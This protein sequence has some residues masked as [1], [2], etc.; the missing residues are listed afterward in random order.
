MRILRAGLA[1]LLGLGVLTATSPAA[2]HHA[3]LPASATGWLEII[4]SDGPSS[5]ST[6][7]ALLHTDH[8]TFRLPAASVAGLGSGAR[9]A[10][11]GAVSPAARANGTAQPP[12]LRPD[13][14]V[15]LAAAPAVS[16]V[17]TDRIFVIRADWTAP[18]GTTRADVNDAFAK[19]ATW[20]DEVSYGHYGI[21][22]DTGPG[23]VSIADP[24]SCENLTAIYSEAVAA[25]R[26]ATPDFTPGDYQ[27]VVIYFPYDPNCSSWAGRGDM[28]GS[29]V[30][31]NGK[32]SWYTTLGVEITTHELGHNLGLDHSHSIECF[33]RDGLAVTLS[34]DCRRLTDYGDVAD[35]M[36]NSDDNQFDDNGD[37]LAA[38][39]NASQ[40]Q[41]LGWL[42]DH[43]QTLAGCSTVE[44]SPYEVAFG[45]IAARLRDGASTYWLEWRQPAL[46]TADHG[47]HDGLTDGVLLHQTGP[48]GGGSSV[49]FDGAPST[50]NDFSDAA[51]TPGRIVTTPDGYRFTVGT[52]A[53]S[54]IPVTVS[55]ARPTAPTALDVA[56]VPHGV[57]LSW[58]PPACTGRSAL[59][60][61]TVQYRA[62][63]ERWA[64]IATADGSATGV[65][66]GGLFSDTAYRFRVRATNRQGSGP[67]SSPSVARAPGAGS[68]D[69]VAIT[70]TGASRATAGRAAP[71]RMVLVDTATGD[72][73][74]GATVVLQRRA[75]RSRAWEHAATVATAIDGTAAAAPR[76]SSLTQFR[77]VYRRST[78]NRSTDYKA[79][80]SATKTVQVDRLVR[81]AVRPTRPR[82][83]R[84]ARIY[85]TV[86]PPRRGL[87]V[88][89]QRWTGQSWAPGAAHSTT[90]RQRLPNGRRTIGYVLAV[91]PANR[92]RFTYRVK[93]A[94]T[95]T[96]LAGHSRPVTVRVS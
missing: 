54:T 75:G 76:L 89:L 71:Q 18:D 30:W 42:G 38:H 25:Q 51:I 55:T 21:S 29:R 1:L 27:H 96:N 35:V 82:P 84:I 34:K 66:I 56:P 88:T 77:W 20:F 64:D 48:I 8:G 13:Q 65:T 69:P 23:W 91:R 3:V 78:D 73:V 62:G 90:R 61:Y 74:R 16:T 14:I 6:L 26:S 85:G 36:G 39:Y 9:V 10:V 43:L 70:A 31:L 24:G 92:G 22:T 68:A 63:A 5:P 58:T 80:S 4:A 93:C 11:S 28:P 44:L 49:L 86:L 57:T 32:Q 83:R 53:A 52:P 60:G 19:A 41:R 95:R 47:L 50:Q 33:G 17:G 87:Q 67:V 79:T 37:Y 72:P 81:A 15:E 12:L 59:T 46:H 2:A 94:A 40:K 45:T 7:V